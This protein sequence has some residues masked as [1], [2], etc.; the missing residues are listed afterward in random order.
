MKQ[1][2]VAKP[3]GCPFLVRPSGFFGLSQYA[4]L[5]AENLFL[6]LWITA[7]QDY[8]GAC[9]KSTISTSAKDG[10]PLFFPV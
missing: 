10:N 1:W 7:P 5:R 8:N 4:G 2:P 9:R 6:R 3:P